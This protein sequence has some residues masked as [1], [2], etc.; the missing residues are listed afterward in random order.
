LTELTSDISVQ[1]TPIRYC[2]M[3]GE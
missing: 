1:Q 2:Q 3:R